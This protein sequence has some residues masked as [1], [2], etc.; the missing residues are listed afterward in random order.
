MPRLAALVDSMLRKDPAQRPTM[1]DVARELQLCQRALPGQGRSGPAF[2]R[3]L[4][5]GVASALVS[6]AAL[7]VVLSTSGLALRKPGNP[8]SCNAVGFCAETLPPDINRLRSIVAFSARDIWACGDPGILIHHDGN[9][10]QVVHRRL[11]NRLH[12][13]FGLSANDLW[14]VGD[15][16]T[17][18][19]YD[20]KSWQ[21]LAGVSP[22]YLTS[23]WGPRAD[24]LWLVGKTYADQGTLLHYDGAH[25]QPVPSGTTQTLL[26][27][28]GASKD[29]IWAA[30]NQGTVV[31]YDGT[32]WKE[33]PGLGVSAK[34]TQVF[35]TSA[36]DVWAV[37]H[38]GAALHFD[39]SKW[40]ALVTDQAS[41]LNGGWSNGPSDVWLVGDQG[42][43]GHY[44]GTKLTFVDSGVLVNLNTATGL[45]GEHG[46]HL[47]AVGAPATVLHRLMGPASP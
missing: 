35:G 37:G 31:R 36:H 17:L 13:L 33:V 40:S 2:Q 8:R 14:A 39:G 7:W 43:V 9:S 20:G 38:S 10:W 34:L 24:D 42:L 19:H 45:R 32:A 3:R 25:W 6:L 1:A 12:Q 11:G 16:G 46:V 22:A 29:R 28:W 18:L 21:Q 26:S 15:N 23:I 27:I 5:I 44:D 30:G 41:N 4:A 47:W